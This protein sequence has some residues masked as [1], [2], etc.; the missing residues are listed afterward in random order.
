MNSDFADL[1]TL[2]WQTIHFTHLI[3]TPEAAQ[4]ALAEVA[5]QYKNAPLAEVFDLLESAL[6]T[7]AATPTLTDRLRESACREI[8]F[9]FLLLQE[10][11]DA[12]LPSTNSEWVHPEMQFQEIANGV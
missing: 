2:A 7:Y 6:E 1:E 5:L 11:L 3:S 8:E 10:K 4:A 9:F 12:L